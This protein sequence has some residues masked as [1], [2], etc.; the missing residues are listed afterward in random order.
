[1]AQ[2]NDF[3]TGSIPKTIIR[4]ALPLMGAEI[5]N[6]LYNIADRVYLGHMP[7]AGALALT[8]V[9]L[10]F[11]VIL[12]LS[13]FGMLIGM[14]GAPLCSIA[15]GEGD[16][17]RAE[18]LLGNAF[19]LSLLLGAFLTAAI[20]LLKDPV[21]SWIGATAETLPYADGYLSI[22][23]WGT[24]FVMITLGL[25]PFINAQGFTSVGMITVSI[26]ALLNIILDPIFIFTLGMGAQGAALATVISQAA[27]AVWIL[28]FLTGR[29]AIVRLKRRRLALMP[30]LCRRM[31][32]LGAS[33]FTMNLT[34]A[35]IQFVSNNALLLYGSPQHVGVMTII[36][37]IR[38]LAMM[39]LSGFSG[40][41]QPVIGF[42]YGARLYRRVREGIRFTTLVC[43]V[44]AAV[45]CAFIMLFPAACIRI[46][47]ADGS[48]LEIGIPSVRIYF[49]MF[50]A[51]FMQM[52]GQRTFVSL[53]KS[54]YAM[55]FSLL[56]KAF[57][58]APLAW[59]LPRYT[60]LGASGVFWAEPISDLIGSAA[61]FITMMLTV[62]P[63]LSDER[64]LAESQARPA[65]RES[66]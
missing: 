52:A 23:L 8:G 54:G 25:N 45:V 5:I 42:N 28:K 27:S 39:P 48:L 20:F 50:W 51:L 53:G 56:R 37:S 57:I 46:F 31:L 13:A 62:W 9:G 35:T 41:L 60:A 2:I 22:Y 1:M 14:G 43:F 59:L 4:L 55:F 44:Y 66:V 63:K 61:C 16:L 24:P 29:R 3:S 7:G 26:G 6:A 33:S 65:T 19:S 15:R 34:E 36:S 38:Q 10:T 11:P 32:G 12:V 17:E 21:L 18:G 58:V 47:N 49:C 30:A 40:G 64:A